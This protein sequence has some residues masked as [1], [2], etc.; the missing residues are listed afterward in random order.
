MGKNN[1]DLKKY[2]ICGKCVSCPFNKKDNAKGNAVLI[3][4]EIPFNRSPY[5]IFT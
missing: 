2:Y 3:Y 4:Y 1:L 5:T